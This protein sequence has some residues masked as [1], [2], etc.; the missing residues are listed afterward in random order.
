MI[1]EAA[2]LPAGSETNGSKA[3]VGF[4]EFLNGNWRNIHPPNL[5]AT[6]DPR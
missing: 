1:P 6:L 2:A 3:C 4:A 5:N